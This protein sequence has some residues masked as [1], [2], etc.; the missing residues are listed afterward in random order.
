MT[1]RFVGPGGSDVADG[2]TWANRK[3]TLN[4]VEDTPVVAGD[5]IYVGAGSYRELLTCDVSGSSGSPITYIADVTGENTDG[6]GGI[7]RITGLDSDTG[8]P[9]RN[10]HITCQGRSYRTFRGFLFDNNIQGSDSGVHGA[11][12]FGTGGNIIIE[13]CVFDTAYYTGSP[14]SGGSGICTEVNSGSNN[15]VRRCFFMPGTNTPVCRRL[16]GSR[17]I[18]A[19]FENVFFYGSNIIMETTNNLTYQRCL[20]LG[21]ARLEVSTITNAYIYDTTVAFMAL[22]PND[23]SSNLTEDYNISDA[24]GDLTGANNVYREILPTVPV[25]SA[26]FRFPVNMA[27]IQPVASSTVRRSTGASVDEDIH[28]LATQPSGKRYRGPTTIIDVVRETGTV[29]EGST[30]MEIPDA[31]VFY[32]L[33]PVIPGKRYNIRVQVYRETNYSG[34]NPQMIVHRTQNPNVGITDSG[35]SASW[36]SMAH[37]FIAGSDERFIGI[38]LRSNNTATS[39]NYRTYF[40]AL[41]LK[42]G[43]KTG[44]RLNWI[45]KYMPIAKLLYKSREDDWVFASLPQTPAFA[46]YSAVIP[47]FRRQ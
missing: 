1:D 11:V 18:N 26:G 23:P 46:E 47:V 9:Q 29:T 24:Q 4:G 30:S 45:T 19:T 2:L 43:T 3:L 5:T 32:F 6:I 28:G 37:G 42:G 31:G 7:V 25:L 44:A 8:T 41:Q 16:F 15:I 22:S 20:V 14:I 21:G 34:V 10:H 36:N 12:Y 38:E 33:C 40:D 35:A 39:G 13:D 17:T 27:S